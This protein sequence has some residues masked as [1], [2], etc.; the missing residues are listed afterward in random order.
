MQKKEE[1]KVSLVEL[2]RLF[3]SLNYYLFNLVSEASE[4]SHERQADPSCP[5]KTVYLNNL[6]HPSNVN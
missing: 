3:N 6:Q 5:S 2:N 4:I 1:K